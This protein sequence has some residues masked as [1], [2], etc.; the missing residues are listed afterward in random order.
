VNG[1]QAD[2]CSQGIILGAVL[3]AYEGPDAK[4]LEAARALAH[5]G[6]PVLFT[7][8]GSS[9]AVARVVAGRL[10]GEGIRASAHEAGEL[11][12]YGFQRVLRDCLVVLVSQSGRSAETVTLADRLRHCEGVRTVAIVNDPASPMAAWADVVLPMHVG[13]EATVSTKTFVASF[14]IA[15]ALGDALAGSQRRTTDLA[16]K[17]GLPDMLTRIAGQPDIA[18]PGAESMAGV[19][20]LS[21]VARGP[22]YA[23][24]EYGALIFK[25]TTAVPTEASLGAS[26][27]HGPLEITGPTVGVVILEDNVTATLARRLAVDTARLGSPT[28]LLTTASPHDEISRDGLVVIHLPAVP[29]ALV[30]LPYAVMLQLLAVHVAQEHGREPGVL[31]HA[32]KVTASE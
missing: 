1:F 27:R 29:D 14:V 28:L 19:R 24:A 11:L 20:A 6:A 4:A 9:L 22:S 8:M 17:A 12:H 21:I 5:P 30:A 25:E 13:A 32:T 15:H 23:A 2:I 18:L 31:R 16:R 10:V 7:G 26:F 3:D